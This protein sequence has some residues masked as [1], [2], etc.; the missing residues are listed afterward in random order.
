MAEHS[1]PKHKFEGTPEEIE[2]QWYLQVYRGDG[3]KQ[4]TVRAVVTGAVLGSILSLTNLYI[5]LTA[6]WGF[7]VTLTACILSFT[8]WTTFQKMGFVKEPMTIL[9]N[10]CM[11]STASS[12]GYSTGSTL[13]SAFAALVMIHGETMNTGLVMGWVFFMAILGVTMAIPMKR[14]MINIEQLPFP[15]GLAAAETLQVLHSSGESKGLRAGIA[16][17]ISAVIAG[18]SEFLMSGMDLIREGMW[19]LGRMIDQFNNWVFS[20]EVLSGDWMAR[21]VK[22]SWEPIFLAAGAITGTRISL[23]MLLGGTLCWCVFIP[24]V[25]EAGLVG[26]NAGYKDLVQW[27]LWGGTACMVSAGILSFALQ[28]RSILSSFSSLKSIFGSKKESQ[29]ESLIDKLEAPM[30]WFIWGQIVGF[31]GLAIMAHYTFQMS[32]WASALAVVMTFF[33]ALVASRVTGETDITPTGAMGKVVQLTFGVVTPGSVD[34]NI[35][36]ANIASG[37]ALASADLLTDIKS[38]YLLGANPRKQFLAQFL[39]IFSGTVFSVLGFQLMAQNV[40]IG[41]SDFPAPGGQTWRAVAE[42]MSGGLEQMHPVKLWS[43]AIGLAVGIV[44]T[45]IMHF[46]PRSKKY[47]PAPTALGLSWTF[48]WYYGLLFTLGALAVE[49]G[50]RKKKAFTEEFMFPIASGVIAG[51]ALMAVFIIFAKIAKTYWPEI[52]DWMSSVF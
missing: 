16:L 10:N 52:S 12:S 29:K 41:G 20:G 37:A 35:T 51:G 26:L 30:S 49:F 21:T 31:L 24:S 1:I 27:S 45:L 15:T 47:L 5:G 32:W 39:G 34:L 14:Q 46:Y 50:K 28:W 22:L 6:G 25:Q 2:R 36:S 44:L 17:M 18:I 38:G 8:L 4:L 19:S 42:A 11:Q 40:E 33:L 7:G 13:V 9:E 43:I 23:S 48:H 3:M